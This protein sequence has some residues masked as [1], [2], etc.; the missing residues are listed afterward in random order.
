MGD[1]NEGVIY[2]RGPGGAT[3]SGQSIDGVDGAYGTIGASEH[4]SQYG[5]GWHRSWDNPG[6]END[7]TTDHATRNIT[8]N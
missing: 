2:Q 5:Q 1:Q 6:G 8:Q 3:P 4:V 7:H